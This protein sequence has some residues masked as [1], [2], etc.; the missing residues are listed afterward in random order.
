M[1]EATPSVKIPKKSR[2]WSRC[3]DT[4]EVFE[5]CRVKECILHCGL[6][7]A[8]RKERTKWYTLSTIWRIH[9]MSL[10]EMTKVCKVDALI[11]ETSQFM[12]KWGWGNGVNEAE[13]PKKLEEKME[14]DVVLLVVE[15]GFLWKYFYKRQSFGNETFF[16]FRVFGIFCI[17]RHLPQR[18][19]R[20]LSGI[21]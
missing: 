5:L 9:G 6:R 3:A 12:S 13:E 18:A 15:S 14:G 20:C 19:V 11:P 8:G 10:S 1:V 7:T 16:F 2:W 17:V 4:R 21:V